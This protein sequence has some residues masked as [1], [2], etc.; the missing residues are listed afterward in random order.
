M[1]RAI[2]VGEAPEVHRPERRFNPDLVERNLSLSSCVSANVKVLFTRNRLLQHRQD[3][4]QYQ[5]D[6][7]QDGKIGRGAYSP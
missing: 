6:G 7:Q 4:Y 2:D 1:A 5:E 3:C